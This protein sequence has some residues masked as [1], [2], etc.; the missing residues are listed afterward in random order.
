MSDLAQS[1]LFG[2]VVEFA[3]GD[4]LWTGQRVQFEIEK[5]LHRNPN[6]SKITI[7]NLSAASRRSV[8]DRGTPMTLRAGYASN[9]A[10]IFS[11]QV[12]GFDDKRADTDRNLELTGRDGDG[13]WLATSSH[14]WGMPVPR[15]T[16][17]QS[18]ASD[19]GL[20]LGTDAAAL[21]NATGNT[22]GRLVCHGHAYAELTKVLAPLGLSWSIQDGGLQIIEANTALSPSA[23]LLTPQTGLI[24]VPERMEKY[25]KPGS[26]RKGTPT[27]IRVVSLLQPSLLPG[28]QVLVQSD[29]LTGSYIVQKASFKGDTHGDDWTV[30]CE[31]S[32]VG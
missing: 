29:E 20:T 14:S 23:V 3:V 31:C 18:L 24:G 25:H 22:R 21:V 7:T 30:T 1:A 11:G 15:L 16:V 9:I 17:V 6:T 27:Q 28:R 32:E 12:V 4:R 2:R 5:S 8:T 13:A 19:L 26:K 10:T